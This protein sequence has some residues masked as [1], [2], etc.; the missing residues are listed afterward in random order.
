MAILEADMKNTVCLCKLVICTVFQE[1]WSQC[2]SVRTIC[3]QFAELCMEC[4]MYVRFV[5]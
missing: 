2:Y 4:I 3:I 1:C 5:C